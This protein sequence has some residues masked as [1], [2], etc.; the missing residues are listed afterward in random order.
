MTKRRHRREVGAGKLI[1]GA[2]RDQPQGPAEIRKH[3]PASV[4]AGRL[5][6]VGRIID[7]KHHKRHAAGQLAACGKAMPLTALCDQAA[8]AQVERMVSHVDQLDEFILPG[9][10]LPVPIRIPEEGGRR[11]EQDL[12]DDEIAR[13]RRLG[14]VAAADDKRIAG[15]TGAWRK[16]ASACYG[17]VGEKRSVCI[18]IRLPGP[19]TVAGRGG[20]ER[21]LLKGLAVRIEEAERLPAVVQVERL[22][23][24]VRS[25]ASVTNAPPSVMTFCEAGRL[26]PRPHR[27]NAPL[28]PTACG[29]T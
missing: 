1:D 13:C 24:P 25:R 5:G 4:W 17:R 14:E 10:G 19:G 18:R 27:P 28:G 22:G 21:N 29:R 8:I 2:S 15:S 16:E 23:V 9:V 20:V 11:G 12:V 6:C 3:P 7:P 26:K